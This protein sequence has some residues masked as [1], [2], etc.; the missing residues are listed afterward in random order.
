MPSKTKKDDRVD[1]RSEKALTG[2]P[3]P[4][5]LAQLVSGRTI[6][7]DAVPDRVAL[8]ED[9]FDMPYT[10]LIGSAESPIFYGSTFASDGTVVRERP[11]VEETTAAN[12]AEEKDHSPDLTSAR[13]LADLVRA[14]G[15]RDLA[16]IP[17]RGATL[18]SDGILAELGG[19]GSLRDAR[20]ARLFDL[21]V[22]DVLFPLLPGYHPPGFSWQDTGRFFNEATEFFD[23]VQG[24]VADCYFIAALSSVAW[25]SPHTVEDRTRA[26]AAGQESFTHQVSF[27]GD[28]GWQSVEVTDRVLVA[29]GGSMSYF[30]HSSEAGEIWPA[31]Y[32]KAYAKWRFGTSDDFPNIPNLAWGDPVGACRNL[33]GGQGYYN[34][35]SGMT[36]SQL[37]TLVKS[38][39]SG[40][41]TTT[42]MVSWSHGGGSVEAQTAA[43]EAGIVASH[44][45]SVL[46]WMRRMEWRPRFR[47]DVVIPRII[48]EFRRPGP[49][50]LRPEL[51]TGAS[52]AMNELD[53][54][55][56]VAGRPSA[57]NLHDVRD[58]LLRWEL[59]PVDYIVLRNPWGSTPGTGAST[60]GGDYRARDI[61]WW[62]S[63][64]LG[65]GGTFAL[66]VGAYREYFAGTGGTDA[67]TP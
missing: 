32:E 60:T 12:D 34:W 67:P 13:T 50:P 3:S 4:Y 44:A 26:T 40:G 55:Q 11:E 33:T 6:D 28:G 21:R 58:V 14:F 25:A 57:L 7:W 18:T 36:D 27:F 45:Y 31:V 30:A 65:S 48:P 54:R 53:M 56:L 9:I 66:E 24:Q 20:L 10:E 19:L 59:V 29:S 64:P 52:S 15:D 2:A 63:T 22:I 49:G 16:D 43:D 42:P 35:H 37:L 8:L 5:A 17:V 62:R 39:C 46:G 51:L 23:P 38:R 1:A 47:L 61:S 41:R